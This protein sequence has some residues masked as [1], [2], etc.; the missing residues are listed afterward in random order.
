MHNVTR[1][2]TLRAKCVAR[3]LS[4]SLSLVRAK[5]LTCPN[6]LIADKPPSVSVKWAYIG[7]LQKCR[8]GFRDKRK[9]G[10]G[11]EGRGGGAGGA[12]SCYAWL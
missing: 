5:R 10:G 4:T 2:S 7:D 12:Y 11:E 9:Q 6:A 3:L 8:Q 1:A